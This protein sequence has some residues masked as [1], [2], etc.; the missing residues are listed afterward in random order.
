MASWPCVMLSL[1]S[2]DWSF[3]IRSRIALRISTP[4][5]PP[6]ARGRRYGSDQQ[7]CHH[8]RRSQLGARLHVEDE[9][10]DVHPI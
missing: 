4:W 9:A 5:L 6:P 3:M 8:F 2:A 1:C 10:D 7:A